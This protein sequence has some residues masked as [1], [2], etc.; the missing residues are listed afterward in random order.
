[1]PLPSAL[2]CTTDAD[3]AAGTYRCA[4]ETGECVVGPDG[5]DAAVLDAGHHTDGGLPPG[6]QDGGPLDAGPQ[7]APWHLPGYQQRVPIRLLTRLSAP[8]ENVP[9]LVTLDAAHAPVFAAGGPADVR[10][11]GA[12]GS[13]L[14]FEV[15]GR[16]AAGQPEPH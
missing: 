6:G 2:R 7:D 13:L 5:G 12:D 1:M 8:V 11:V 16:V 3:C 10:F 15:D 4:L 14:P 9:V